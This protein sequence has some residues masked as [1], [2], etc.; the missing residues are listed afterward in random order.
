MQFSSQW[1]TDHVDMPEGGID[2]LSERLTGA[3]LA[4]EGREEVA[5]DVVLDIDVTTNR[6]DCMNHLGL[7]REAAVLLGTELRPPAGDPPRSAESAADVATVVVEDFDLCPRYTAMVI[8]GVQVGPSPDW[9]VQRLEAIGSRSVNNVVDV[10]NYVLWE[11][12]QP[13]HAFDLA[14]L[15]GAGGKG[16]ELRIRRARDGETL[17]TLDGE[18][19]KLDPDIL[20]IADGEGPTA[21]AGVMGGFDSEVTDTTVDV[22]LE[23]AHFDPSTVRKGSSKLAMHTDASHRFERGADPGACLWANKRAAALIVELA[24]GEVLTGELDEHRPRAQW[25]PTVD[26]DLGRLERFAGTDIGAQEVERILGGLGFALDAA[27][28]GRWTVSAPSWRYYDFENPHAQD[29]YEEVLRIFGFD[30]LPTT[31]PSLGNP[32]GRT[33][34]AHLRRKSTQDLLAA[35]GLAETINFAFHD[36]PSADAWPSLWGDRPPLSLANALS[37]RYDTMRRS[38]LPNLVETARYNLRRGAEAVRLF[39]IGHVFT[40]I[41]GGSTDEPQHDEMDALAIVIG[42]HSGTPWERRDG[43]DFFDLKGLLE[44]LA[45]GLGTELAFRAGDRPMLADGSVAEILQGDAVVGYAGRLDEDLPYPLFV[46]ELALERV[47]GRLGLDVT[48]PSKFPGISVDTTLTHPVTVPWHDLAAAIDAQRSP[49][50]IRF[51]L[52]NRYSGKGVPEGS[53]NTT[54]R[55]FYNADDRSLTQ[56]QVNERHSALAGHLE[57]RFAEAS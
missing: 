56:D 24:G 6:P 18:D 49:E 46:A 10:T 19:R 14:K 26:L 20:I 55:F 39:E 29:V 57:S 22:L 35:C 47:E 43:Y 31:L 54:I 7:A 15:R 34:L 45:E 33:G 5:G 50:L 51:R 40:R 37:D 27:G 32:D 44:A 1:I 4:V 36:R 52:E 21:L 8:R 16:A 25:P 9:L 11:T 17:R 13:L 28:E 48:P 23:S 53:V 41:D 12:G 38:L 2:E 3:G 42:G 30:R